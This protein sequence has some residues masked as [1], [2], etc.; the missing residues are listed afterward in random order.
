METIRRGIVAPITLTTAVHP[1]RP[2]SRA[3]PAARIAV[4]APCQDI[5]RRLAALAMEA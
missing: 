1:H 2:S 3:V 4:L 5:S